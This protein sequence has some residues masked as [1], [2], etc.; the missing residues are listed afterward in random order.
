MRVALVFISLFC[1]NI[2]MCAQ[3]S[4]STGSV[5]A[6]SIVALPAPADS[7]VVADSLPLLPEHYLFTQR[8]LWSE[9]G[10]MRNFKKFELSRESRDIE[11]NIRSI[12]IA[13]HQYLGYATL[14]GMVGTG[15]AGQQLYKGSTSNKDLHE[16]LAGFTNICYYSTAVLALFQPPP[17]HNRASGFTKLRIHRTLSIIHLSSMIATNVLSGL[18]EDNSKLKPYHKAA[19]ITAFSSLFLATVVIKL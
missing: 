16:G 4:L 19:A 17:M 1:V 5:K 8:L 14:L 2:I 7:S 15:I 18:Q 3:D 13:A 12:A 9:N 6:D 10:L 11:M